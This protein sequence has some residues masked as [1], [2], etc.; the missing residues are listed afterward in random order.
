MQNEVTIKRLKGYNNWNVSFKGITLG[1]VFAMKRALELYKE[2]S[3]VGADVHA[4]LAA[5]MERGNI[6]Y[7]TKL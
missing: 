6:N 7:D 4:F 3:P 1:M 2:Q 5:A